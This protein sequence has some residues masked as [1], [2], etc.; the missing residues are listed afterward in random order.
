V[1]IDVRQHRR[2]DP[3]LR[4]SR[5]RMQNSPI[6]FCLLVLYARLPDWIGNAMGIPSSRTSL[7]IL[8]AP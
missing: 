1:Q 5:H 3:A 2:N 4:R 8:A 6:L 7:S